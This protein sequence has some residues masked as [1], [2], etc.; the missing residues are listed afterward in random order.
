VRYHWH[1]FKGKL[2][3]KGTQEEVRKKMSKDE[4]VTIIVKVQGDMPHLSDPHILDAQYIDG[5]AIIKASADIRFSLSDELYRSGL[6]I[7]E[8]RLEEKT[9]EDIFLETVYGG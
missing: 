4:S 3:V 8:M 6:R 7:T 1:H 5:S 9:L 2:V